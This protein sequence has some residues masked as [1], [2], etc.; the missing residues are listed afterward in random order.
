MLVFA[1]QGVLVFVGFLLG[2]ANELSP[3]LSA[4][5]VGLLVFTLQR[6]LSAWSVSTQARCIKA[7]RVPPPP[8]RTIDTA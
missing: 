2:R 8:E 6:M 3:L 7:R 4:V 1:F 5:Y